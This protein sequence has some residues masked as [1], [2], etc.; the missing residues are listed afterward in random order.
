MSEI[1]DKIK[2]NLLKF[3]LEPDEIDIYLCLLKDSPKS[4]LDISRKLNLGRNIVYRQ[5]ERLEEKELCKKVDLGT[6]TKFAA[7]SYRNLEKL[8]EKKEKELEEVKS[9][10]LNLFGLLAEVSSNKEHGSI[11]YYTGNEGIL[12]ITVNSLQAK[13]ELCILELG[14]ISSFSDHAAAEK[15]RQEFVN[16]KI[17]TKQLTN[18]KEIKPWTDVYE[19]VRH[20]WKPRYIS[21]EKLTVDFEFLIYDDVFAMYQY[22]DKY[23][24][25]GLEVHSPAV[26]TMQKQFFML[27]WE[28]AQ[29]MRI[30]DNRGHAVVT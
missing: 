11:K 6:K 9:S 13:N 4:V 21:A 28:N 29:K 17:T 19:Q 30:L 26:A 22:K 12:Q 7:S 15:I 23:E 2:D 10:S 16:N 3:G 8:I 24:P 1:K 25:W 5:V 14:S 18:R 20:Y 27:V